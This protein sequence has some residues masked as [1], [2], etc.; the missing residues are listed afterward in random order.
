MR[1]VSHLPRT[2]TKKMAGN[3]LEALILYLVAKLTDEEIPASRIRIHKLLYLADLDGVKKHGRPLTGADWIFH[4]YGPWSPQIQEVL[5]NRGFDLDEEE[6]SSR[7]RRAFVYHS[8]RAA[9][10]EPSASRILDRTIQDWGL[11]N[12]NQLLD[13]IYFET[14]PM[15]YAERGETLNLSASEEDERELGELPK[16]LQPADLDDL[17]ERVERLRKQAKSVSHIRYGSPP[18]DEVHEEGMAS[19]NE[20]EKPSNLPRRLDN[21]PT[22]PGAE[23]GVRGQS[24]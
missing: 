5:Q 7:G 3:N 16:S 23:Q 9:P 21:L 24:E 12:L 14:A 20:E 1:R 8:G 4:H 18:A 6:V 22:E 19:L 11:V 15:M 10:I 13:Y 2:R 17:K